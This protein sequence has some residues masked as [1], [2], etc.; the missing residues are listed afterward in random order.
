MLEEKPKAGSLEAYLQ[1]IFIRL[2]CLTAVCC[3]GFLFVF[4]FPHAFILVPLS[5]HIRAS[6]RLRLPGLMAPMSLPTLGPG[7]SPV[8]ELGYLEDLK[9]GDAFRAIAAHCQKLRYSKLT[10]GSMEQFHNWSERGL[11]HL[12]AARASQQRQRQPGA[13]LSPVEK[14]LIDLENAFQNWELKL[15]KIQLR[16]LLL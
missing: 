15:I 10:S 6:Q 2:P 12:R 5:V 16:A 13:W 9:A 4:F 3:F 1:V 11:K 8:T 7:L 14:N